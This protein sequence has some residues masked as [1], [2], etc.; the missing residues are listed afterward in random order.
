MDEEFL[1]KLHH[2]L[3]EVRVRTIC[4]RFIS[5]LVDVQIQVEEGAMI[6]QNCQ[7]VYSVSN[8]IP[9]MVRSPPSICREE[10]ILRNSVAERRRNTMICILHP[11]SQT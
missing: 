8:G 6:C 2:V 11:P 7:H 4:H 10:M 5:D 3:M 9:N 1:Q